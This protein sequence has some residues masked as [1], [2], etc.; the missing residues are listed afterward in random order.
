MRLSAR[1]IAVMVVTSVLGAADLAGAGAPTEALRAF[2]AEGHRILLDPALREDPEGGLAAARRLIRSVFDVREAAARVLGAEW[3]A[4]T[5]EEQAEFVRLFADLM[6]RAYLTH[7]VAR[8]HGEDGM[9]VSYAGET[10]EGDTAIVDTTVAPRA[11]VGIP[12]QYRMARTA[13]RWVVR[14]VVV[15]GVSVVD[16]YRS[17]AAYVIRRGS[18]AEMVTMLRERRSLAVAAGPAA[19]SPRVASPSAGSAESSSPAELTPAPGAMASTRSV[20]APS[21]RRAPTQMAIPAYWVQLGAFQDEGRA[22]RLIAQLGSLRTTIAPAADSI[23]RVRVGP[24]PDRAAAVAAAR[25]LE[26]RGFRSFIVETR[27]PASP[28]L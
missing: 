4:R 20:A 28:D 17:Q 6:E 25:E 27:E 11:G 21:V 14:D 22:S 3:G 10:R 16:N 7:V 12:F 8:L 9:R 26:Q 1:M 19:E 18:Y 2:F 24:F 5:P 23:L 15:D 13:D